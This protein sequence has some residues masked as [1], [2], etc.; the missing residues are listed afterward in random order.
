MFLNPLV[1][2]NRPFI[3]AAVNL[4]QAGKIFAQLGARWDLER[5]QKV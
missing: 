3:E 5:V 2:R 1:R 4:Q